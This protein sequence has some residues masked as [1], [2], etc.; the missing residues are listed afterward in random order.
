[1]GANPTPLPF[2]EVYAAL[3]QKAIDGQENPVSVI[4]ANKFWEVQKHIVLTNHQYNPQSVLISKKFWDK[5]DASE[6]KIVSDAAKESAKY[7]RNYNRGQ[8]AGA[9]DTLKKGGMQ[10]TELSA[11]EVTKLVQDYRAHDQANATLITDLRK[12]LTQ[13]TTDLAEGGQS[14]LEHDGHPGQ[15][16][17]RRHRERSPRDRHPPLPLPAHA[18]RPSSAIL[19]CHCAGAS[20]WTLLPAESTATVTGISCTVNS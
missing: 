18:S 4:A 16:H 15:P 8:T 1:M 19:R 14:W 17:R 7:Q 13:L 9:L 2:P 20:V 12:Q 3:E 10:V 5:L 6:K 11:A